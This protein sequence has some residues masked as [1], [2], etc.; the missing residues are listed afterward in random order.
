MSGEDA[1]KREA[2]LTWFIYSMTEQGTRTAGT[3]ETRV[4]WA[5]TVPVLGGCTCLLSASGNHKDL[6]SVQVAAVPPST[7]VVSGGQRPVPNGAGNQSRPPEAKLGSHT[8]SCSAWC[9]KA[10][11]PHQY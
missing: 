4:R 11:Q 1:I 2:D 8:A 5:G 9:S 3:E 10:Q 6:A 7:W